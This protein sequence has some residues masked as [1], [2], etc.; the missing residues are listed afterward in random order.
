MGNDSAYKS[1][2]MNPPRHRNTSWQSTMYDTGRNANGDLVEVERGSLIVFRRVDGRRLFW[3]NTYVMEKGGGR[4]WAGGSSPWNFN[5]R[6]LLAGVARSPYVRT[7]LE[8]Q[9]QNSILPSFS[10]LSLSFLPRVDLA[11]RI[12]SLSV[13]ARRGGN[14]QVLLRDAR[15]LI[16][17]PKAHHFPASPPL[18]L[19]AAASLPRENVQSRDYCFSTIYTIRFASSEMQSGNCA[20]SR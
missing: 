20:P 16:L 17:S 3:L 9:R 14:R 6:Q 5:Q 8:T 11:A 18:L 12:P 7:F 10:P 1:L 13:V 2:L 19:A 15:K 4:E